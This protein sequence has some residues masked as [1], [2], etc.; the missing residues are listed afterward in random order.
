LFSSY[1]LAC[2]T[3]GGYDVGRRFWLLSLSFGPDLDLVGT[4]GF[5]VPL[6][7]VTFVLGVVFR[8]AFRRRFDDVLVE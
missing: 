4:V 3:A 5:V 1:L 6:A 7:F 2:S 8:I